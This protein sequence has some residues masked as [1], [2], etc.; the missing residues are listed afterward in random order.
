MKRDREDA[1]TRVRSANDDFDFD[2]AA[3][4]ALAIADDEAEA[5][6]DR[7]EAMHLL[8]FIARWFQPW[9]CPDDGAILFR[10]AL[11]VWPTHLAA[12]M[13]LCEVA[14]Q[15]R[16]KDVATLNEFLP[17]IEAALASMPPG[18]IQR[19][20]GILNAFGRDAGGAAG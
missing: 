1:W 7:A 14:A 10:S 17:R 20:N 2:A 18:Y 16:P 13:S 4:V 3:R 6:E 5:P 19:W 8:G 12:M 11:Q 15:Q 9:R